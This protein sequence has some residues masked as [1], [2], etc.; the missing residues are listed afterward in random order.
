MIL[1]EEM[2]MVLMVVMKNREGEDE[3]GDVGGKKKVAGG[4]CCGD[5]W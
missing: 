4:G 5:W 2:E 3:I 1:V